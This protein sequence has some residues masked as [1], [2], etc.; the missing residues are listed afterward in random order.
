MATKTKSVQTYYKGYYFRSRIE[1]RYAVFLDYL[2]I[3]WKYEPEGYIIE[4]SEFTKWFGHE[5]DA[6]LPDFFLPELN[7]YLEIKPEGPTEHSKF[8]EDV[9]KALAFGAY[10]CQGIP[11]EEDINPH[12]WIAND[13]D[14][15]KADKKYSLLVPFDHGYDWCYCQSQ[16][17]IGIEYEGRSDRLIPKE[18]KKDDR[19]HN[20]NAL[21]IK[22]A[23]RAAR[24]ARFEHG[25][26]GSLWK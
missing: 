8:S 10:V 23:W 1:A 19:G 14:N 16:K 25:Q 17:K 11:D 22:E 7:I 13:F 24:T 5:G 20:A 4:E 15:A 2:A 21:I 9:K 26:R 3:L 12:G 18:Q 6:Y